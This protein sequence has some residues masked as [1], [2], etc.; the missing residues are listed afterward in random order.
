VRRRGKNV[1]VAEVGEARVPAA[2]GGPVHTGSTA[3]SPHRIG[4][5]RWG[6]IL[7][8]AA[9]HVL[10][11]RLQVLSAGISFFALLSV[12]PMLVTALSVYGAL[13]SPEQALEQLS[14]AAGVLPD[15][16]EPVVAD[17]LRT[18]T[19]ASTQVLTL[20]GLTGLLVAL[21]TA[22]TAATFLVDAL[23]LAYRED[24]TRG[25]LRRSG[26]AALI[27]LGGA[28]LLGAV[29]AVSG[30]VSRF[31]DG[32]PEPVRVVVHLL[33]WPAF[34]VVM[35]AALAALYRFA[36]DRKNARWRWISGG[37]V[38]ATLLWLLASIALFAYVQTLGSYE[39]TYGS[40][41]GVAISMFWLWITVF[42]VIVGAAVNAETERET[43]R[44]STVGPEQPVG[45]RGAAVADSVPPYPDEE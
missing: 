41:A 25:F 44:D 27:V 31:A 8:R 34:A 28:V 19:T 22:T 3:A 11:D 43:V 2:A 26:L 21:W 42:L 32:A 13:N 16:L 9:R 4:R 23:T 37:A 38:L 1:P 36:P 12:A 15:Q 30:A 35:A 7:R 6:R 14:A 33:A 18:I 39:A 40:L 5:H 29:I 20:R 17:Q 10:G 45:Q 24:E